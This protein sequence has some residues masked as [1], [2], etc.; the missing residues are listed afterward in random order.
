M[1]A[2]MGR[3]VADLD[4]F[5]EDPP[6]PQLQAAPDPKP[7]H[8]VKKA[9]TTWLIA[10]LAA[11]VAI[12]GVAYWWLSRSEPV[13]T[14]DMPAAT[15]VSPP[16]DG[17]AGFAELFV[18]AYLSG[19]AADISSFAPTASTE[20]MTPGAHVVR[21][22]AAI[23]VETAAPDYWQV[24]IAAD[25]L[26]LT[27]AG[28]MAAGLQYFQVGVI[29]DG[30][31]LVAAGLPAR[32]AAPPARVAPPRSLQVPGNQASAEAAAIAGDF[33]EALLTGGRDL[34][35]YTSADSS[36]AAVR[37]APY[38]A[39]VM[40]SLHQFD[41]GEL[42]ATVDAQNEHGAIHN[43]QYTLRLDEGQTLVVELMAGPPPIDTDGGEE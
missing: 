15:V 7:L 10:G 19:D 20:A 39:V 40:T 29:D 36:I 1:S 5:L 30:G 4:D 41:G 14:P 24:L 37:P 32:V 28:Y 31:R 21:H 2:A 33:F 26:D 9:P 23:E 34:A 43:L 42:L 35:R 25:V 6:P 38:V 17:A 8:V 3:P 16:A 12:G 27:T 18:V 13:A 22:A 11:A